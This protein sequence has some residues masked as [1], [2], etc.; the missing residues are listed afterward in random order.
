[1]PG[2]VSGHHTVKDIHYYRLLNLRTH[3]FHQ[4]IPLNHYYQGKL[5]QFWGYIIFKNIRVSTWL[6]KYISTRD[7]PRQS[8]MTTQLLTFTALCIFIVKKINVYGYR[9]LN[10][11]FTICNYSILSSSKYQKDV[12]YIYSRQL[13][14]PQALY[15]ASSNSFQYCIRN[16]ILGFHFEDPFYGL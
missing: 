8:L 9:E 3:S 4:D 7:T 2:F 1:M 11:V 13:T 5:L 15:K 12:E 10:F 14:L 16:D 6:Y